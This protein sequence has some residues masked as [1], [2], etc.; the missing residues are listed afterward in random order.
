MKRRNVHAEL[1]AEMVA[2]VETTLQHSANG[3]RAACKAAIRK[4]TGTLGTRQFGAVMKSLHTN[5]KEL[6]AT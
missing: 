3:Q 1:I 4:L 6:Y 2:R 5:H